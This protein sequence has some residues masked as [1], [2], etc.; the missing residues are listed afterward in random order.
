[1]END[2][3]FAKITVG[4]ATLLI[5]SA[6]KVDQVTLSNQLRVQRFSD[7]DIDQ[8]WRSCDDLIDCYP[9]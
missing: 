1:M 5:N 3:S 4:N 8:F 9:G 6:S 2:N 7:D